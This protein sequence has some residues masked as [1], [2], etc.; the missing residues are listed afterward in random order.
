MRTS[1]VCWFYKL[2]ICA[3]CTVH[4]STLVSCLSWRILF[5]FFII[6]AE[7]ELKIATVVLSQMLE[8]AS[9]ASCVLIAR[10]KN[11]NKD[12][13]V[14]P[15]QETKKNTIIIEIIINTHACETGPFRV[16]P[17][18]NDGVFIIEKCICKKLKI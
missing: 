11:K 5:F 7:A 18:I 6:N 12:C 8:I 1:A 9:T 17:Y 3:S 4:C 16:S 10:H 14:C 2:A 13:H 15:R